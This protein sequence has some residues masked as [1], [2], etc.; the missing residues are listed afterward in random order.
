MENALQKIRASYQSVLTE[1]L[2]PYEDVRALGECAQAY[3]LERATAQRL[4]VTGHWFVSGISGSGKTT[5][6]SLLDTHGFSRLPNVTTR[7]RRHG[8][9]E[10]D[11]VFTDESTFQEWEQRGL[12]FHPHTTNRVSHAI[13]HEDLKRLET[14][15]KLYVDKSVKSLSVLYEE[16]PAVKNA[17]LIYLLAPT[18]D[19]LYERISAREKSRPEGT[20][21]SEVA[22]L[23]RFEEEIEDM[24]KSAKLPYAY[25]V[26][27]TPERVVS[28]IECFVR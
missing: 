8:E 13:R 17:N 3:A 23:D 24:R 20:A 27:D 26:N 2:S 6:T 16:V 1:L 10:T 21:L 14:D 15:E 12:L 28:L 18:F 22:I 7:A 11:Y 25:L 19:E 9:R 5:I 4:R